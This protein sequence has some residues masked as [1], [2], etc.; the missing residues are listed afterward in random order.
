MVLA[1]A[2]LKAQK[3]HM[4]CLFLQLQESFQVWGQH[5]QRRRHLQNHVRAALCGRVLITR[6]PG[7]AHMQ[8]AFW[9]GNVEGV[10]PAERAVWQRAGQRRDL[11]GRVHPQRGSIAIRQIAAVGLGFLR[12]VHHHG[13]RHRAFE[14]AGAPQPVLH[15]QNRQQVEQ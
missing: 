3:Q 9:P 7:H 5:G 4:H 10:K 14:A 2:R 8:V 12:L 11:F 13:L 6:K 15:T 1:C